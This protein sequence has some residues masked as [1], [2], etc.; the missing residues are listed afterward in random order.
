M[1]EAARLFDRELTR[2]Q[3]AHCFAR[4][5]LGGSSEAALAV[6]LKRH[7]P[8]LPALPEPARDA[9]TGRLNLP[10]GGGLLLWEFE[11]LVARVALFKFRDDFET[12]AHMKVNEICQLLRVTPGAIRPKPKGN[13]PYVLAN[14]S[15]MDYVYD[16]PAGGGPGAR[17]V[18][19][20]TQ[21]ESKANAERVKAVKDSL[22][23]VQPAPKEAKGDKKGD[24]G[25]KKKK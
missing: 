8:A 2:T 9:A 20:S 21:D 7:A 25:G 5:V 22:H 24:K 1:F 11:E 10:G 13:S 18:F 23:V 19:P 3:M 15:P 12:P 6:W 14:R 4:V 16:A 17:T